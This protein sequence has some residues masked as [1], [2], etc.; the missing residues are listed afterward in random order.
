[1]LTARR[2][3]RP[4]CLTLLSILLLGGCATYRPMPLGTRPTLP[5]RVPDLTIDS[6]QMPLPELAVHPFDPSDGLDITEVAMLAVVNNP[7]LRT[8]RAAASIAHAQAFAAGLLPDPQLGVGLDVPDGGQP[9]TVTAY[10]FGLSYD[11]VGL[12]TRSSR[13]AAA[14]QEA[15][16]TDLD[17]LWREW[18]VVAQARVLF[19]RL[20]EEA[21]LMEVLAQN[22]VLFAD[23][24]RRTATA[25]D[26]G[27][28]SLDTVTPQLTALQDVERQINDLERLQNQHRHDL[29]ALLGIA[30]EVTV[31]LV[32][33]AQL[34]DLDEAAITAA[35]ETLPR[36]RPDLIALQLGY[37]A[38]EQRYRAAILAQFPSLG[39]GFTR[40]ADTA[41]IRTSGFGITLTLPIFSGNR[42]PIAVERATREWLHADYQQRLDAADGGIHRLLA[43][44]RINQR[45]LVGID[46]GLADL[47]KA[48]ANT[49][50]A[51]REHNID[52]LAFAS[53]Q[54][55]VLAKRI[56]RINLEEMIL[57][58][59][60]ALQTL[61]GGELPVSRTAGVQ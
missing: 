30:P 7:D 4:P 45:Q 18:Q 3:I 12:L 41:N 28:M 47:S 23:R 49:D 33:P 55:A 19:V 48:A 20:T 38:E 14:K 52:A 13:H 6:R 34:P 24:Y 16:R 54:S 5:E 61:A 43:E 57:E 58:Q 10:H 59:R 21:R 36:R 9:G 32:G 26:R 8:A 51:F 42:G 22:R 1:M 29:N 60:V 39:I 46:R 17:L 53:L 50:A 15:A 35:I 25:L 40:A 2:N 31:P 44:Q 37:A 27:L 56:E 11:V